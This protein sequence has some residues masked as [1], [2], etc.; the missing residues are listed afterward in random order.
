M[1][2]CLSRTRRWRGSTRIGRGASMDSGGTAHGATEAIRANRLERRRRSSAGCNIYSH[3]VARG[4]RWSRLAHRAGVIPERSEAAT[5]SN[6]ALVGDLSSAGHR[7][8]HQCSGWV[9]L[10]RRASCFMNRLGLD[11]GS[12]SRGVAGSNAQR[13]RDLERENWETLH[14]TRGDSFG[15]RTPFPRANPM[16]SVGET[17]ERT[18][19]PPRAVRVQVG[20]K[21]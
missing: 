9:R 3:P 4:G 17:G 1:D 15:R 13:I 21:T 19:A 14:T 6:D 20:S 7:G 12:S 18:S 8:R 2:R 16:I 10:V 5:S 11:G